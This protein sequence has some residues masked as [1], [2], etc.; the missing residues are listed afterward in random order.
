MSTAPVDG[1]GYGL[2]IQTDMKSAENMKAESGL[3]LVPSLDGKTPQAHVQLEMTQLSQ[4]Q[5]GEAIETVKKLRQQLPKD[6]LVQNFKARIYVVMKDNAS[7][8]VSFEKTLAPSPAYF[9]AAANN[10]LNGSL[11]TL[12]KLASLNPRS[13]LTQ[14]RIA[15]VYLAM[16]NW[17]AAVAAL[18]QAVTLQPDNFEA[19]AILLTLHAEA[20]EF[21][22]AMKITRQ[23]QTQ[24]PNQS[25]GY[26]MEG[27]NLTSQRKAPRAPKAYE[28]ATA[29]GKSGR[30]LIKQH[31][32]RLASGK[33]K[34]AQSPCSNPQDNSIRTNLANGYLARKQPKAAIEQ[35]EAVLKNAPRNPEALTN[36][37]FA[38]HQIKDARNVEVAEKALKRAPDSAVITDTTG[39]IL[40]DKTK[41]ARGSGLLQ[42]ASTMLPKNDAIRFHLAVGLT[43]AGDKAN[44]REEF[45]K[46]AAL[47][48]FPMM[49]EAKR[50]LSE[51]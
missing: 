7:A 36:L 24:R 15:T 20:G 46:L 39:W 18:N 44:T 43:K 34:A 30:F 41:N 1:K 16:Q 3:N 4:K 8:R 9:P 42:K 23:V 47:K 27:N 28:Q 19:E 31:A 22:A 32:S 25:V 37:A 48:T 35:Y 33:D 26:T 51:L 17:T 49:E 14:I 5:Y 29:Q 2:L 10:D 38:Y 6:P 12:K 45:T 13:A 50:L 11:T 21:D 40:V